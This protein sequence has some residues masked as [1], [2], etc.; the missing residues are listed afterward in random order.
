M[1]Y[2]SRLSMEQS[3]QADK[4]HEVIRKHGSL[5]LGDGT[6][7]KETGLDVRAILAAIELL[8]EEGK[9]IVTMTPKTGT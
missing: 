6:L 8:S 3:R 1:A 2:Y 9:L 5:T 7:S 4:V